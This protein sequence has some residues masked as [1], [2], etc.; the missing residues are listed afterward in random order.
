MICMIRL[1]FNCML[2]GRISNDWTFKS[3][4]SSVPNIQYDFTPAPMDIPA[5]TFMHPV[6]FVLPD[7]S[8]FLDKKIPKKL[9]LPI[10][11]FEN[12]VFDRNY[13]VNLHDIVSS[14]GNYNY[15]GARIPLGHSKINVCKFR[16][17]LPSNFEDLAILQYL[18]YGFPLGLIEDIMFSNQF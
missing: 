16:F 8:V 5:K 18:E 10:E 4:V 14:F 12:S 1:V 2:S 7:G 11:F 3:C 13:Y 15:A 17:L 6:Y 9:D